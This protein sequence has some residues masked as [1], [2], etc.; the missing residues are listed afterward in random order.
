MD[1]LFKKEARSL[2]QNFRD[3]ESKFVK[4]IKKIIIK[5]LKEYD[6]EFYLSLDCGI[7]PARLRYNNVVDRYEFAS[8]LYIDADGQLM[9]ESDCSNNYSFDIM[10]GHTS[11]N[12]YLAFID[13]IN[14]LDMND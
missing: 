12:I 3:E 7:K 14:E 1:D 13:T 5:L 10:D 9:V 11:M 8:C 4:K 2:Y 6:N